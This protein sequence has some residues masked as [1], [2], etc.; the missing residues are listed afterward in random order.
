MA[1]SLA[2]V[3]LGV[4]GKFGVLFIAIPDPIVGGVFIVMFG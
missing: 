4:F 3:L 1:S 2:M